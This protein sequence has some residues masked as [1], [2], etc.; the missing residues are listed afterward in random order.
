MAHPGGRHDRRPLREKWEHAE[1]CGTAG[2]PNEVFVSVEW[3]RR[4]EMCRN[5]QSRCRE[6]PARRDQ[7]P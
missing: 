6:M 7:W 3:S 2:L 5:V 1:N 4:R